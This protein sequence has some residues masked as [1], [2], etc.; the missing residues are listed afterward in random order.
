MC[1]EPYACCVVVAFVF[2]FVFC[3]CFFVGGLVL[4]KING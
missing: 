3:F 2:V 4:V 1:C